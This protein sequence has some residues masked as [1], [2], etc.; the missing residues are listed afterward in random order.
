M[1]VRIQLVAVLAVL[2][3]G[4]VILAA[5]NYVL[6]ARQTPVLTATYEDAARVDG[7][8]VPLLVKIKEIKTDVVQVQQWLTDISATRGRDGLDDGFDEAA[9]Y[10]DRF[11]RD[12]AAARGH[13]RALELTAVTAALDEAAAAFDPYYETGR[14]MARAYVDR[15]PEGGNPMMGDFDAVAEKIGAAT[16]ALVAEVETVAAARL[17]RLKRNTQAV[18][19]GN[20]TVT[21]LVLLL[22]GVGLAVAL[23]GG[24]YL[25][26]LFGRA[27]SALQ[28]DLGLITRGD[29]RTPFALDPGRKDEF[30][31]LAA[32][33]G[34]FRASLLRIDSL[35]AERQAL[36]TRTA[37]D[38]RR[39]QLAMMRTIVAT[40]VEAN[41]MMVLLARM[42]QEVSESSGEVNAM[43][44]AI[45][46]MSAAI[47]QISSSSHEAAAD[48]DGAVAAAGEGVSASS[49]TAG[50]IDGIVAAIGEASAEVRN[51]AEASQEI[52]AIVEQIEGIAEQTNLLALNATI[53]S[54]RAGEAGKGFAV[55]AGEVKNLANQSARS[56]EDIRARITH[57]RE[58][59]DRIVGTI[60]DSAEAVDKGRASIADL[61]ARLEEISNRVDGVTGRMR[62]IAAILGEQTQA[63]REVSGGTQHVADLSRQNA[64]DLEGVLEA[65]DRMNAKLDA[66]VD[67]LSGLDASVVAVEVA[68]NDHTAFKRNIVFAVMGRVDLHPDQVKDHHACRLGRWYDAQTDPKI[69]DHPVFKQLEEPHRRVHALGRQAVE[70]ARGGHCDKALALIEDLNQTSHEVVGLLD[71]LSKDLG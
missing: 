7:H 70:A 54:A 28:F 6:I 62:E 5:A 20:G 65:M 19:D 58:E 14:R 31:R 69:L 46:E 61:G 17:D 9:A 34:E 16:D 35:D 30:G 37:E 32:A 40:A 48:A 66:E 11:R 12:L 60:E 4:F 24:I 15:G 71:K 26:A 44:S 39:S 1:S 56:T 3:A 23:A 8:T 57:L 52:G 68:K 18:A 59:M 45:E 22:A 21:T 41:E 2:I 27:F 33:L 53:E 55:V 67:H 36:E 50:S 63:A 10:A 42:K 51:L 25:H 29:T 38:R 49:R 43:A 47:E 13:A 64:D